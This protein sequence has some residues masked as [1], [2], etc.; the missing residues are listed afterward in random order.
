MVLLVEHITS[1]GGFE[2]HPFQEWDEFFQSA[3]PSDFGKASTLPVP[4][5]TRR[6]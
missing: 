3:L 4:A 2:A 1:R 5:A 6:L